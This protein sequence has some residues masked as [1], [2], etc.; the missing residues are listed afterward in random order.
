[1]I[2]WLMGSRLVQGALAAL[3]VVGAVFMALARAKW[4]GKAEAEAEGME[5]ALEAERQRAAVDADV[6]RGDDPRQR[7]RDRWSRPAR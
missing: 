5:N 6:A 3:A 4:Q 2:A 1:M 7:L